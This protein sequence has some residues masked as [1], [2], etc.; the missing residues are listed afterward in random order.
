MEKWKALSL[1]RNKD[2][3]THILVNSTLWKLFQLACKEE[4]VKPNHKV[5]ELVL[6]YL[7]EKGILDKYLKG[8][9]NLEEKNQSK[10]ST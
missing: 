3:D 5:S 6:R 2:K 4:N 9:I 7:E 1:L 10:G 8:E